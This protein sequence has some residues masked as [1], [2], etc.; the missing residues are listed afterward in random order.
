MIKTVLIT[1]ASSGIGL[2]TV[3]RFANE[4]WRVILMAR[5]E[6]LLQEIAAGLPQSPAA[7][8]IVAAGD[9]SSPDS[10][11]KLRSVLAAEKVTA[12]DALVSCAGVIGAAHI[13]D[14]PL[15]EW[16][17][18]LDTLL[19]GAINVTRAVVPFMAGGGRIVHVTSIHAERAE[20]LSSAYATAKAAI[21]E[22][23][24]GLALELADRG[25]LVN[26]VAPG[27]VD[28]PMSVASDPTGVSELESEWFKRDYVSGR[29]LPLRRAGRPEEIAGVLYFLCGP[30][31]T[32]ITGQNIVVDGG[33]TITF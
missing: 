18:P 5:R 7:P 8:H 22:Y 10:M 19:N 27:F 15:G 21:N 2:A 12:I 1:G 25:I 30:D 17:K 28:T 20:K 24:R 33:M 32:Y 23:C 4:G 29:H 6:K 9:Y 13:T 16:R 31:A 11:E 14:S 26:T 3:K